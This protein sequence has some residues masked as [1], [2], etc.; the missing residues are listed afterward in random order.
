VSQE[1]ADAAVE[2]RPYV[3]PSKL[4]PSRTVAIGHQDGMYSPRTPKTDIR[5]SDQLPSDNKPCQSDEVSIAHAFDIN[6][7]CQEELP[8]LK[9]RDGVQSGLVPWAS[10][11]GQNYC[12]KKSKKAFDRCNWIG[13][14]DCAQNTCDRGEVTLA[15]NDYGDSDVACNCAYKFWQFPSHYLKIAMISLSETNLLY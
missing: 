14:G 11:D 4:R 15:T 13:K 1:L 7:E 8:P 12:C 6:G 5:L 2:A 3:A 9:R 10:N